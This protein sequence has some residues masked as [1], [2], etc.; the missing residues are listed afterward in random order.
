MLPDDR[1]VVLPLNAYRPTGRALPAERWLR[2]RRADGRSNSDY[3]SKPSILPRLPEPYPGVRNPS[4]HLASS[5]AATDCGI[6]SMLMRFDHA[7]D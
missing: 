5:R 1:L 2:G 6:A 7:A 3:I 4:P